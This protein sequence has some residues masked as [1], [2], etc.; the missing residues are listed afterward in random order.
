MHKQSTKNNL[1]NF[2]PL[3]GNFEFPM[4]KLKIGEGTKNEQSCGRCFFRADE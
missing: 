1:V 2:V 4:S 3:C